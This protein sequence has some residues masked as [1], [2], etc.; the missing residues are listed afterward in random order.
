MAARLDAR[1]LERM[2]VAADRSRRLRWSALWRMIEG[3]AGRRGVARLKRIASQVDPSAA[4]AR[5]VTEVDF[6]ALCREAGIPLPQVNVIVEGR[7]VDFYWPTAQLIVETDSYRYHHD[8]PAFER[9][10]EST[11]ALMSAGYKVL[12][13][14]Y[15]MLERNPVPFLGLVRDSLKAAGS[16]STSPLT[17]CN[18]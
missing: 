15:K 17:G 9:D 3:G 2:I 5:S 4:D 10:H 8:R 18:A 16:M 12:R 13:T 14:T 11:V 7:L 1:Q 6:L